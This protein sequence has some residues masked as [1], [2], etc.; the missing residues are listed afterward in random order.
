M[1]TTSVSSGHAAGATHISD[2]AVFNGVIEKTFNGALYGEPSLFTTNVNPDDL[3]N[4]YLDGFEDPIERQH[5]NCNCCRNFIQRYGNLVTISEEGETESVFWNGPAPRFFLKS[6]AGMRAMVEIAHVNGVFICSETK[7]GNR[8]TGTW[9]HF[10]VDLPKS[11]VWKDRVMTADQEA[12][13]RR[14]AFAVL[15]RGLA[16]F[17]VGVVG[18]A[19]QLLESES[20]YRSDKI[21]GPAQFLFDLH[22]ARN[23]A[24]YRKLKDNL[25]WRALAKAP[26]GWTSPRASMI[27]TLL[28]DIA[29]GMSSADVARRFKD[30]M[31]PLKYQRPVAPA[32]AGNIAQAEKIVEQLGIAPSLNR[33]MATMDDLKIMWIP[34]PRKPVK[35]GGVFGYLQKEKSKVETIVGQVQTITWEKFARTVLPKALE[36]HIR[37]GVGRLPM[38]GLLTAAD[39]DAPP[40]LQWDENDARNPVNWYFYGSGSAAYDWGLSVNAFHKVSGITLKPNMWNDPDKYAHQGKGAIFIIEGAADK[41]PPSL[42]LFPEILKS[43][44]NPI[45]RTIEQHSNSTHIGAQPGQVPACGFMVGNGQRDS[46]NAIFRVTTEIGRSD[47]KIDRWD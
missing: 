41:R 1:L 20:L 13:S 2:F 12:A 44:L 8:K 36:I 16:A 42:C 7:L 30:K 33:R 27:G 38:C 5:H 29:S 4:A 6:V 18:Q 10:G 26:I 11:Y 17:D 24:R 3:W 14:E 19:V 28:E 23:A 31:D 37:L 21:L 40:I 46:D 45:R 25:V 39:P 35:A 15:N 22:T 9:N 43:D 47:Y 32:S 34:N